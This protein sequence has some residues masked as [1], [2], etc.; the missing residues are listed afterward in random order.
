MSIEG[1]RVLEAA[2][3]P[4]E[5]GR[6]RAGKKGAAKVTPA[7]AAPVTA[8]PEVLASDFSMVTAPDFGIPA[9]ICQE[10]KD[11]YYW[12]ASNHAPGVGAVVECGTWLGASTACLSA[13]LGG[14]PI[15]CFDGFVWAKNYNTKSDVKL[16]DGADFSGLFKENMAARGINVIVHKAMIPDFVWDGSPIELLILDMGKQASGIVEILKVF[17]PAFIPGQTR[18]SLQDYQYFPGAPISLVMDAIRDS[19][20]LEFVT[21]SKGRRQP[22]T[23]SFLVTAPIDIA[24]LNGAAEGYKTWSVERIRETWDRI[25]APLPD[26]ARGRMAP[27]LAVLMLDAGHDQEAIRTLS[28]IEMDDMMVQRWA[29]LGETGFAPRYEE[30]FSLVVPGWTKPERTARAPAKPARL[31]DAPIDDATLYRVQSI[32]DALLGVAELRALHDAARAAPAG[33]YVEIGPAQGGSSLAIA[34]GRKSAGRT[35]MFYTADVF[36]TSNALKSADVDTNVDVLKS[37]LKAFGVHGNVEVI[38]VPRQDPAQ[39]IPAD[40]EIG[41]LFIDADGALDRDFAAFYDR[42]VP[43]GTIVLDD[44]KDIKSEKY[45]FFDDDRL[46][47]YLLGKKAKNIAELTPFEKEYSVH[48]FAE[49]LK[50]IGLVSVTHVVAKTVF[51]KKIGGKTYAEGGAPKAMAETRAAIGKA[52][53]SERAKVLRSGVA[54][55][56]EPPPTARLARGRPSKYRSVFAAREPRNAALLLNVVRQHVFDHLTKLRPNVRFAQAGVGHNPDYNPFVAPVLKDGWRGLFID[57][58][59]DALDRLRGRLGNRTRSIFFGGRDLAPEPGAA[60][61]P[62]LADILRR[63]LVVRPHVIYLDA[64]G[65]S[66]LA[67]NP[68]D[69]VGYKPD[70]VGFKHG[71][72][73]TRESLDVREALADRGYVFIAD[74]REA[75]AL[76]A[77]HFDERFVE[78]SQSV[79]AATRAA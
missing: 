25:M 19:V 5:G 66:E 57:P 36:T 2:K 28:E 64:A 74:N 45:V 72:L 53:T 6:V 62:W 13:G 46:A 33:V 29:R 39:V 9:M 37:N 77:N 79:M 15:H 69:F 58:D 71:H 3:A 18:I 8:K 32:T 42:V 47:K 61:G 14:R 34:L 1:E 4:N 67:A 10:E 55:T 35:D 43:G 31:P 49:T 48:R 20:A 22:N 59:P 21:L 51:L 56:P 78:Y 63:D 60:Q 73:T 44:C 65:A 7:K 52:F 17:A 26:K 54:P 70:V 16:P 40:S 27:G 12:L 75:I 76:A 23:V 30:L 50:A 68:G 11:F 41:F 24:S 38:V